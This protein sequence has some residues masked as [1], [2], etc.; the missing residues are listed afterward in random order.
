VGPVT[1]ARRPQALFPEEAL[2]QARR[3][4]ILYG[5]DGLP[6]LSR[7]GCLLGWITRADILR[8]LATNLDASETE[9]QAGAAAA[10]FA[11]ADPE[12]AAHTP[13]TPLRGYG[14][15]EL[16][17]FPDSPALGR[18]VGEVDWPRGSI[19]VAVTQGREIHAAQPDLEL[20]AGERVIV[21]APVGHAHGR[22]RAPEATPSGR[23]FAG[24]QDETATKD[25]VG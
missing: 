1:L 22:Q 10:E 7:E 3:Q 5:R 14:T 15:L 17:I 23:R 2:E 19:P 25:S 11:V 6:V 16:R 21:L 13:S 9:A 8:A 18:R 12:A 24:D 20:Q 4:L